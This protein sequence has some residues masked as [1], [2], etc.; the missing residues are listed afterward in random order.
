MERIQ[1]MAFKSLL[2]WQKGIYSSTVADPEF[3]RGTIIAEVRVPTYYLAFFPRK[4]HENERN[5]T[6]LRRD[7]SVPSPP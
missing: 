2:E 4:L 3:P 5:W 7:R 1:L 6:G